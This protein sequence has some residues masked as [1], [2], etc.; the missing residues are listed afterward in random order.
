MDDLLQN[1]LDLCCITFVC[2]CKGI[3]K[4]LIISV[5]NDFSFKLQL[6][7]TIKDHLIQLK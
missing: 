1:S 6:I 5:E 4:L 2:I 3:W 7:D